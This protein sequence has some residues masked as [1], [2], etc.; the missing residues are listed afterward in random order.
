MLDL[1][2]VYPN[3]YLIKVEDFFTTTAFLKNAANL[4]STSYSLKREWDSNPRS[5]GY[6]PNEDGLLLYPAV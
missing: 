5:L 2:I 3:R 1:A 4:L 6:E